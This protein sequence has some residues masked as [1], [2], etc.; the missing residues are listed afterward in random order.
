MNT[1]KKSIYL[2]QTIEELAHS[3]R[4]HEAIEWN[5]LISFLNEKSYQDDDIEIFQD[6][7]IKKEEVKQ[8]KKDYIKDSSFAS[9]LGLDYI[10]KITEKR[11]Q[12]TKFFF[13]SQ[14]VKL[15]NY[16]NNTILDDLKIRF[17]EE[18]RKWTKTVINLE[19]FLYNLFG[20]T[21]E[22]YKKNYNKNFD[23][24]K[25]DFIFNKVFIE[26]IHDQ[27]RQGVLDNLGIDYANNRNFEKWGLDVYIFKGKEVT[28]KLI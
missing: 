12:Q 3:F 27:N 26:E 21:I 19:A 20:L 10:A 1:T 14:I 24:D 16:F 28:E 9:S 8:L 25:H 11:H 13:P 18:S 4:V 7:T 15:K 6:C 23:I 2:N 17:E 5:N 22:D